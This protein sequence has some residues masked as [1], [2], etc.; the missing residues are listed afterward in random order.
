[1]NRL[2][3]VVKSMKSKFEH[4][5]EVWKT[6]PPEKQLLI[7]A[8]IVSLGR[9]H[10]IREGL[11]GKTRWPRVLFILAIVA[12]PIALYVLQRLRP[13]VFDAMFGYAIGFVI[14]GIV[15]GVLLLILLFRGRNNDN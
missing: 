9:L 5:A 12:A 6:L 3:W 10:K 15:I 7:R 13:D 11:M 8:A 14:G 4:A 2:G 1:M